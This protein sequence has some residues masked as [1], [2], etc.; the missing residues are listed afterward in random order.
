MTTDGNATAGDAGSPGRLSRRSLAIGAVSA[1]FTGALGGSVFSGS[2][3]AAPIAAAADAAPGSRPGEGDITETIVFEAG[4]D[5]LA[6]FHVF[7]LTTTTAGTVLA[8]A[9]ARIDAHDAAPH[10]IALR[11]STDGG[12]TWDDMHYVRRSDGV[13]SFVNPT[14]VVDRDTGRIFLF[15]AECFR[16]EGNT[17]GS[18][19]RSNL[20]V[21][22]S[23]DDGVSWSEL[24]ELTALFDGD[25]YERTLH[26]PGPGHGIQ[27]ADGRLL[28]QV[29][30]RRAVAFPVA[31]R[32]YSV[33][34]IL[35]DDGG[36]SWHA[37]G[38]VPL[39]AKYPVNESRVVQRADGSL[40][41]FGRYASGGTHPRIVSVSSDRGDTWSEP[42]LDAFVRPVNAVDTGVARITGGPGAEGAGDSGGA[43]GRI[44]FSRPDSPTRR[45]LTVSISYDEGRTWPYSRVLTDG[46]AS[47]S[48][49]VGLADG[50]VG[51]LY[52]REHAPGITTSFS[53]RIA[54]ASFDLAW[55]TLGADT[56]RRGPETRFGYTVADL[57][58][59]SSPDDDVEIVTDPVASGGHRVELDAGD[60]GSY[61]EAS[62]E[63]TRAG[64]YEVY[65]RFRHLVAAGV[66]AVHLDDEPVGRPVDTSTTSARSFRTEHLGR[67]RLSRGQHTVRF[68]VVD[69][70]VDSGG[71]RVSPDRITLVAS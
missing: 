26:M 40:V 4:D 63:V 34:V 70:H 64:D 10:H 43:P 58:L 57:D 71:L 44:V 13:Q 37:G 20:Y 15:F 25:P 5:G 3:G 69:K 21:T 39:D 16:N 41:L 48:D 65:A 17:G 33:S 61:V 27:L 36:A 9:E 59:S 38:A 46:P 7:G 29:W 32:R 66:V 47:Y 12:R 54:F 50:R 42:V 49:T 22:S 24:V 14:P 1:G 67:T 23:D 2:A 19:D 55:L 8:F 60:Y 6:V 35:S 56:G 11:R 28:L 52:G 45:N 30:H 18:P 62:I 51:V 31:E 53:A 68:T